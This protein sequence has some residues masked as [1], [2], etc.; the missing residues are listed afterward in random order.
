[1]ETNLNKKSK[2]KNVQLHKERLIAFQKFYSLT[3]I[4][5]ESTMKLLDDKLKYGYSEEIVSRAKKDNYETSNQVAWKDSYRSLLNRFDTTIE[6]WKGFNLLAFIVI[7]L[8]KFKKK[9]IEKV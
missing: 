9:I 7:A 3:E 8:K 4:E 1:L 2:Q 5:A 6:S